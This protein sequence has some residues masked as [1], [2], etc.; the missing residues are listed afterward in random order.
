MST[1]SRARRAALALAFV[2]AACS[3]NG[4]QGDV[5]T[6]PDV[7]A[8]AST[9]ASTPFDQTLALFVSYSGLSARQRLAIRDGASWSAL[10]TTL[11]TDV[12]PRPAVPAV[13]FSRDMILLA[14]M[15]EHRSGGFGIA[16][17]RVQ[18]ADGQLYVTVR[19]T[20]PGAGCMTTQAITRPLT[21]VLVPRGD[22]DVRF[23]ERST[24]SKC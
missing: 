17:E 3:D 8:N 12:S 2:T 6:A 23:V 14:A 24:T 1:G 19:E 10:W 21:A 7:P 18:L 11:S 16:I 4:A 20:S 5:T 9:V 22:Y 13:D 15:G